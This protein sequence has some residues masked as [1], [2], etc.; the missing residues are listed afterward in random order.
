M[1]VQ[2]LEKTLQAIDDFNSM[3]PTSVEGSDQPK[4]LLYSMQMT[5]WLH[6]LSETPSDHLKLAARGQ[7]IGRWHIPR[8]NYPD[9][10][11]GYLKWRTELKGFHAQKMS[12]IMRIEGWDQNDIDLV[13]LLILK[14]EL[15]S[16]PD[17]Q[18]LE[19]V[20]CLVFLE[21]YYEEFIKS[22]SAE[23]VIGILQKTWKKMSTQ[24]HEHAMHLP[25]S[26]KAKTLIQ[27][28]L[29]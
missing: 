12:E 17:S 11:P 6:K 1:S 29:G 16:N 24:G 13:N 14:K 23:K 3:D 28:A 7:H 26:D 15:K 2:K 4:E 18:L 9:D 25:Y 27:E 21:F 20:V 22:H 19:D 10:R 8:S 5:E